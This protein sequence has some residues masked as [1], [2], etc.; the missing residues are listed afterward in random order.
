MPC[1]V[2]NLAVT[3]DV[4]VHEQVVFQIRGLVTAFLLSDRKLTMS[5]LK[6]FAAEKRP[7][8]MVPFARLEG[9]L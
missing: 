6:L 2:S 4:G 3:L 8:G 7:A 9:Q 1:A 5:P